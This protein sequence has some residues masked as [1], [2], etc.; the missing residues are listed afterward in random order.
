M[1]GLFVLWNLLQTFVKMDLYDGN[2]QTLSPTLQINDLLCL[3]NTTLL[4][5]HIPASSEL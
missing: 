3:I 2:L 5:R 1:N 4:E